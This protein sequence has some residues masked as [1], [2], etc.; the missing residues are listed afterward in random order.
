[1]IALHVV[2]NQVVNLIAS[3]LFQQ[4]GDIFHQLR[5]GCPFR[6]IKKNG[7]LLIKQK[8]GVIA[9]SEGYRMHIFK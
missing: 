8:I 1:M 5:A 6:R 4:I 2:Y 7:T 9:H 3:V